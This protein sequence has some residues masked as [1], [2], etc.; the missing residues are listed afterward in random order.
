VVSALRFLQRSD[1][2]SW[3]RAR[4]VGLETPVSLVPKGNLFQNMWRNQ[5]TASPGKRRR[6][7]RRRRRGCADDDQGRRCRT[8]YRSVR[9]VLVSI[10]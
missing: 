6:R 5:L 1:T 4:T 2:A 7:R 10:L 9:G 3:V 8:P